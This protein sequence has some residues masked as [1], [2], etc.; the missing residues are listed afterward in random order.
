MTA[1]LWDC[2]NCI[3]EVDISTGS[4]SVH[5]LSVSR[6]MIEQFFTEEE[7]PDRDWEQYNNNSAI[8]GGDDDRSELIIGQ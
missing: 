3:E 1:G 4:V 8:F 5:N 2:F 6:L 7:G